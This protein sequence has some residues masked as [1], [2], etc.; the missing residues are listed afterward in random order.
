MKFKAEY[1]PAE[2]RFYFFGNDV[3]RLHACLRKASYFESCVSLSD[4]KY[5]AQCT[6]YIWVS[7][8]QNRNQLYLVIWKEHF[9]FF[10]PKVICIQFWKFGFASMRKLPVRLG[11]DKFKLEEDC[12]Q[13]IQA[14]CY[15]SDNVNF[16]CHLMFYFVKLWSCRGSGCLPG[17]LDFTK[18]YARSFG[19]TLP[20]CTPWWI[21][22]AMYVNS[23]QSPIILINVAN[24]STYH[25][26]KAFLLIVVYYG[27]LEKY[28]TN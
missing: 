7:W 4:F 15:Q 17:V 19:K 12:L 6:Q 28:N 20:T 13:K 26:T 22:L 18:S 11:S 3:S 16:F 8:C 14:S 21:D 25:M 27:K 2:E 23:L 24:S 10:F 1:F 9:I 5:T